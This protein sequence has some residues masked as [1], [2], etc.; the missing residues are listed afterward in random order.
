MDYPDGTILSHVPFKKD[1]Y[2]WLES[3]QW[4][5]KMGD[6]RWSWGDE[7]GGE[8]REILSV[9][10]TWPVV[11]DFGD[12]DGGGGE[13]QGMGQPLEPGNDLQSIASKKTDYRAL[14]PASGLNELGCR[15]IPRISRRNAALLMPWFWHYGS[16]QSAEPPYALISDLQNHEVFSRCFFKP[17]NMC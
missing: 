1:R 15:F 7:A 16:R 13:S 4:N 9:R 11:A 8:A 5:M 6:G 3:M 10:R 17:V 12:G 14:N 2:L